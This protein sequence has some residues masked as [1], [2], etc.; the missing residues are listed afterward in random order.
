[1]LDRLDEKASAGV[2]RSDSISIANAKKKTPAGP[3]LKLAPGFSVG[4]FWCDYTISL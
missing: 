2:V 3:K 1:M 4:P